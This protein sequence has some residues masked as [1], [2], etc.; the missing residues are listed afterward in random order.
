VAHCKLLLALSVGVDVPALVN[1]PGSCQEVVVSHVAHVWQVY[2]IPI[3][4]NNVSINGEALAQLQQYG[5]A[6]T[7]TAVSLVFVH[8]D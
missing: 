7:S 1:S 6:S 8:T 3:L 5:I 2:Y 4:A